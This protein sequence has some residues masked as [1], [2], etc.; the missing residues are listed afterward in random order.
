VIKLLGDSLTVGSL[1]YSAGVF[2]GYSFEADARGG[3]TTPG[4]AWVLNNGGLH[5]DGATKLVIV[6][7]GTNDTYTTCYRE[8]AEHV[9][10]V[11]LARAPQAKVVWVGPAVRSPAMAA[12]R[13]DLAAWADGGRRFFLDWELWLSAHPEWKA[14]DGVHNTQEGYHNRSLIVEDYARQ[15]LGRGL[16]CPRASPDGLCG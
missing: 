3:R 10:S 1:R 5:L 9:T 16:E 13:S 11:I 2:A 14:S 12:V 7:L 15:V 6:A 4:G 8:L